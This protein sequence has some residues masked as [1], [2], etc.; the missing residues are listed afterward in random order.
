[1]MVLVLGS[2]VG[3]F[4]GGGCGL[5]VATSPSPRTC[6]CNCT[7]CAFLVVAQLLAP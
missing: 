4:G 2:V 7:L 5:L 6:S 3:A 1:M